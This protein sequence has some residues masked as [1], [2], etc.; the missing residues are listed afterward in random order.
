MGSGRVVR[1]QAD[2]QR[3]KG[4]PTP[5]APN[6]SFFPLSKGPAAEPV[7]SEPTFPLTASPSSFFHFSNTPEPSLAALT[8]ACQAVRPT[9]A[10]WPRAYPIVDPKMGVIGQAFWEG[11]KTENRKRGSV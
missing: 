4:S 5:P 7:S 9:L 10:Q 2:R 11:S 1:R 8:S 6:R 3:A